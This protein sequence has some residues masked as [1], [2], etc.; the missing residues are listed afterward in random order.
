MVSFPSAG[1]NDARCGAES[2]GDGLAHAA[3]EAEE[4]QIPAL[5]REEVAAEKREQLIDTEPNEAYDGD[6]GVHVVEVA[7]ALLLINEGGEPRFFA[8]ELGDD[9]VRPGPAD[10]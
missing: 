7:I 6:R 1:R 9:E 2:P 4:P 8:D 5:P 3:R 10:E